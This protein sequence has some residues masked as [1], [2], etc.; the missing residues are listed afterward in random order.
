MTKFPDDP[1]YTR[2]YCF[3]TNLS[4]RF[5]FAKNICLDRN[6]F[7]FILP[8]QAEFIIPFVSFSARGVP[9]DDPR[10]LLKPDSFEVISTAPNN[11]NWTDV[12][13]FVASRYFN[14]GMLWHNFMDYSYPL[15]S[16]MTA[17]FS[18]I[19]DESPN[20]EE[21]PKYGYCFNRSNIVLNYDDHGRF[22]LFFAK[23]L[24][25]KV[26]NNRYN[27]Q[28]LCYKTM[29][30]GLRKYM[31]WSYSD[32]FN[33]SYRFEPKVVSGFRSNILHSVNRT[34]EQCKP[35]AV[36]PIVLIIRRRGG[37]DERLILNVAEVVNATRKLCPSCDVREIDFLN[38][39]EAEQVRI[40]CNC[41]VLMG[42]H[43]SGLAQMWW[44][45]PWSEASPTGVVEFL[46]YK[47]DCRDWYRTTANSAGL[48]Y[49][50]VHTMNRNQTKVIKR[51]KRYV[52][53]CFRDGKCRD[54][55]CHDTLKS[56]S[57]MVDIDYYVSIVGDFFRSVQNSVKDRIQP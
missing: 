25:E 31:E 11:T 43:G 56:Q 7:R 13:A 16:T 50:V 34:L 15:Y 38:W 49:F 14:H 45:T 36:A 41:S 48:K 35:S 23:S 40:S 8:Y 12:T 5:C 18:S 28:P 53:D 3:G 26:I 47:Y 30:L 27:W 4:D 20:P 22:G 52:P 6:F 10:L 37:E 17:F 9:F 55:G 29:V 2:L 33:L 46:P 1:N 51:F 44:M 57:I 19:D 42:I 39:S 21:S 24:S 54:W 32:R